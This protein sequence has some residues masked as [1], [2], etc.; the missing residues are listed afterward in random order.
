MLRGGRPATRATS[1]YCA[2]QQARRN[3]TLL[4]AVFVAFAVLPVQ[5]EDL[6]EE[7]IMSQSHD[8]YSPASLSRKQCH[9]SRCHFPHKVAN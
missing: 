8:A 4:A 3:C 2:S 6:S 7:V 9:Q 1:S 5:S